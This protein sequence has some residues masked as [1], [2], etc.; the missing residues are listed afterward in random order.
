MKDKKQKETLVLLDSNALIHRAFHALPPL[1]NKEGQLTNAVYG[2]ALTLFSVLEKVK[3]EYIVATFDLK[4]PTFRHEQYKE[5]KAT[6]KKA[7]D[8]LYAQIPLV[9]EMLQAFSI[10][11]YEKKGFEADDVIGTIVR[12]K[13]I[14][15]E[16]E[17]MIVTG[18][19]DALQLV[20]ENTK[21][22]TLRKGITDTVIYD[23]DRV[24]D[25][26][27]LS[28]LQI[29]DYK[30]LKGD[31]SDNIPGVKGVGDKTATDL[32]LEY[33]TLDG[34]YENLDKIK[35]TVKKKLE[36]DKENAFMSYKL[37]TINTE[38]LIDFS[39]NECEAKDYDKE[40][41]V[42]FLRKMGFHTLISRHF[43]DFQASEDDLGVKKA[44]EMSEVDVIKDE[45]AF[46]NVSKL[47]ER[48][49]KISIYGLGSDENCYI[50]ELLGIGLAIFKKKKI[51]LFFVESG[52]IE[53][54][55]KFLK[56]E[57]VEIVGYDMKKDFQLLKK[58]FPEGVFGKF[59]KIFDV[60]IAVYLLSSG[61]GNEIEKL[62][63]E[64]FG[65]NL[66]HKTTKNGQASFL[67]DNSENKKK[68]TAEI[69]GW[70]MVLAEIY[71]KKLQEIEK[72]QEKENSSVGEGDKKNIL[73][74]FELLELPLVKILADMEMSGMQ[75]DKNVL[76]NVSDLA[77]K[78]IGKLEKNI[79]EMAG[80][81][82]NI[83]SPGQLA[84]ILYEKLKI[85]TIG[86]KKGKT[87]FSTNAEQLKK[88]FE[89]HPIIPEVESYREL[90]KLK[91]TYADALPKLITEDGRIH[92]KF[93]QA[94]T[95]TGR[96]SSSDPN[97]QNIPKRGSLA[98]EIR[99]A[100]VAEE[101]KVLLA[102]D[103]SQIDL[104]AAAHLSNDKKMIEIFQKGRDIHR[105]TSAWVNKV[106]EEK[107]TPEQRSE[108][109]SL[110]FGVLYG[111][112]IYGFMRDSGV[113]RDRASFFIEKY[114]ETFSGLK[115]YLEKTKEFA[116]KFGY[117][118]T[119]LG[120]RR[121]I[122]NI[123]NS[124]HMVKNA[125]ERVAINLPV[126]GLSAD[127]MKLAMIKV[128]EAI[129]EGLAKKE[130]ALV[131]Q[132]H[133]ELIFEVDKKKADEYEKKIKEVMEGV[134]ELKVPLVVESSI[135]G[136]WSEI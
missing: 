76:K 120:R 112:G 123:N 12:D 24:R 36:V 13:N 40:K 53:N 119:E 80:E 125:A 113:S 34:I 83:N 95:A 62:V 90:F 97:L 23:I 75:V 38:V 128:D 115:D 2:Y 136:N 16:I 63:M 28:P 84:N 99:K 41:L 114:M 9:K 20:D 118:E 18:D 66:K 15:G 1:T 77:Q 103:Y 100:F 132:V 33:E 86:I 52:L 29:I 65:Q 26:Y 49:D 133:D 96:L 55:L 46:S 131:L 59:G 11:I 122:P 31:V 21:V 7:P 54:L 89:L 19:M 98:K 107:V 39:L 35:E 81:N 32:L 101:G 61:A 14:N 72:S 104:R 109:K 43:P 70:S 111:M 105:S 116:R 58:A 4:G 8:E 42:N 51:K 17:K 47:L 129:S 134:Y 27:N 44:T 110:N 88:L 48:A 135:A 5:Y 56:D 124:N 68:E 130:I 45:K 117:V 85:S 78:E 127:I 82:F 71:S 64:E 57:K 22:F 74:I 87:G 50:S 73:G 108:A 10:P 25:R 94:V 126:Q 79:H 121:Y 6:R 3:P 91:S 69:A 30:S 93:N 106:D 67:D 37:A 102:L 92:A 60:Q